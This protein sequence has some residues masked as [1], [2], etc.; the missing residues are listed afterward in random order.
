MDRPV[1]LP[2]GHRIDWIEAGEEPAVWQHLALGMGHA[3]PGTQPLEQQRREYGVAI[4]A[5]LCVR[6]TYV[7][8]AREKA[9]EKHVA[10]AGDGNI[11]LA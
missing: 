2:R 11:T 8:A 3:P 10:A 1:Q 5:A 9:M 7:V 4:L 6:G